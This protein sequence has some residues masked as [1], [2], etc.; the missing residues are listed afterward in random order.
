MYDKLRES[1]LKIHDFFISTFIDFTYL[2]SQRYFEV[3]KIYDFM[4]VEFHCEI[5]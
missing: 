4:F 2:K 3:S 5:L 1:D